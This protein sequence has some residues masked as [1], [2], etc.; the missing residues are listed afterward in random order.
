MYNISICSL[1]KH[2]GAE[3]VVGYLNS[4]HNALIY[5]YYC[6]ITFNGLLFN[7]HLTLFRETEIPD[8]TLLFLGDG[9]TFFLL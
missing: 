3:S 1:I 7:F 9:M 8:F 4:V 2:L 5:E 6:T